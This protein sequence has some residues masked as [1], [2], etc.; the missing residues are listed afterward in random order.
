MSAAE[1]FGYSFVE[2]RP[3]VGELDIVDKRTG[4]RHTIEARYARPAP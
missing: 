1:Y 4:E 2:R 3:D